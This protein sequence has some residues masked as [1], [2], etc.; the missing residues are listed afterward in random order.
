MPI[1]P[2]SPAGA[3]GKRPGQQGP[4]R[5]CTSSKENVVS[6]RALWVVLVVVV[7]VNVA[8]AIAL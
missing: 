8:V 4:G 5:F 6:N 1:S 3:K 2:E 7:L